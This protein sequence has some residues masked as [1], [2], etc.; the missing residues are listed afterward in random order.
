MTQCVTINL[1]AL[2]IP[3]KLGTK[4]KQKYCLD[5]KQRDVHHWTDEHYLT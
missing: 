3:I 5:D 4:V 2:V 1:N